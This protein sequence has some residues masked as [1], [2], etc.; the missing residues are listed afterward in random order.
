MASCPYFPCTGHLNWQVV[1]RQQLAITPAY[2]FTNF[3]SQGQMI[4]HVVV[5]LRRPPSR[6]LMA[7]N[8]YITL[9][10]SRGRKM[11]RLLHNLDEKLFTTHPNEQLR[12]EDTR[13]SELK[14]ETLRH[15]EWGKF[16]TSGKPIMVRQGARPLTVHF[17]RLQSS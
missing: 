16:G 2:T 4:E 8:T 13:L 11:I 15:Y 10:R 1:H 7:F 9:L 6:T 3:K 5:N 14:Q 12:L 17:G